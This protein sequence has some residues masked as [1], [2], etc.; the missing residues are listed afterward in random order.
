MKIPVRPPIPTASFS[1]DQLVYLFQLLLDSLCGV[2]GGTLVTLS[3]YYSTWQTLHI[4][5]CFHFRSG[6]GKTPSYSKF[7]WIYTEDNCS[8][9]SFGCLFV[10]FILYSFVC[11]FGIILMV[12]LPWTTL[13]ICIFK[14]DI[15]PSLHRL[16][17]DPPPLLPTTRAS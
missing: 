5:D 3:L 16:P 4:V 8:D 14:I 9:G 17:L 11:L 10:S 1:Q 12:V 13:K 2:G 6:L 15:E 7:D